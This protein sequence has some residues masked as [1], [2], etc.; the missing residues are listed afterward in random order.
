MV[1]E[2]ITD[3]GNLKRALRR[4]D[5]GRLSPMGDDSFVTLAGDYILKVELPE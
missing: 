2:A 4:M 3:F 1:K 5:F